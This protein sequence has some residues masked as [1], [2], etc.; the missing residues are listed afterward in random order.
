MDN[1]AN[2][3]ILSTMANPSFEAVDFINAGITSDNTSI[4]DRDRYLNSRLI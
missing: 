2:D 3:W 1:K 4:Y